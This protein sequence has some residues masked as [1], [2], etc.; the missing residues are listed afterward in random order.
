M[1]KALP[2][3]IVLIAVVAAFAV[4]YFFLRPEPSGGEPTRYEELEE[5][6]YISP[7][8][9]FVTNITGSSALTK[10]SVMISLLDKDEE[11]FMNDNNAVVRNAIVRV[12]ISH[13]EEEMR[14][15]TAINMLQTEMTNA[16]REELG[17]A[18]N[19]LGGVLIT[20]FVIQ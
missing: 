15:A 5:T 20:D 14:A 17:L 7:G 6:V 16:L 10:T 1:K 4:Y 9:Y 12:L 2:I 11:E 13:P 19:A 8:D 18:E 3:V